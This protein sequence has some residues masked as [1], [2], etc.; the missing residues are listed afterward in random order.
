MSV[1]SPVKAAYVFPGQGSQ[2]VGMGKDLYDNFPSVRTVFDAADKALGYSLSKICFEGPEE[3]LK[4]TLNAQPA[5]LTVSYACLIAAREANPNGALPPASYV[6]GHSLGEYTALAASGMLDFATA[7]KLARERGHLMQEAGTVRPGSMA[8]VLGV[9]EADL[10]KI[11]AEAGVVIGNV[12]CPGQLVLSGDK[13]K[14][15]A[16]VAMVQAR[17]GKAI[18]LA[19]SA[20]FHSPLMA[21]AV[22]GMKAAFATADFGKANI[23]VVANTTAVAVATPEAV[24]EEL[25]NQITNCVQWQ[26][27]V[28][29]MIKN[30]VNTFIEMGPGKVLTGCI[31][32]IDKNARLVNISDMKSVKITN[33]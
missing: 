24:K 17:K 31:K 2:A 10:A 33:G 16:A 5:I 19:V 21:P 14:V 13:D 30:G 20:A 27:S 29:F 8:A 9:E 7:L 3:E 26:K 11:A 18:P 32:R 6:A 23:P 22:P 1:E 28:E 12:N 25:I 4:Q 15:S